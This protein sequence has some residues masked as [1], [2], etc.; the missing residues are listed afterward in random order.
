M[1][2]IEAREPPYFAEAENYWMSLC[3]E[4]AQYNEWAEWIR[5]E[6]KGK[7]AIRIGSLRG[8]AIKKSDCFFYSFPATSMTKRR[9]EH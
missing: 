1:K 5:R 8:V 3:G 7:L 4:Q 9:V 6:Q 2:N